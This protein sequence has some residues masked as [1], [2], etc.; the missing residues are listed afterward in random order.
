MMYNE[1]HHAMNLELYDVDLDHL[2]MKIN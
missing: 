1:Y 2:L